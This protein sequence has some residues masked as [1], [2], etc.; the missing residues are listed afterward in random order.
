MTQSIKNTLIISTNELIV[1]RVSSCFQKN[2]FISV[3]TKNNAAEQIAIEAPSLIILDFSDWE[4]GFSIL[5]EILND[6]W[7]HHQS[8]IALCGT[9]EVSRS[10]DHNKSINLIATISRTK[11]ATELP[12]ILGMLR[13]N[14]LL[15][16]KRAHTQQKSSTIVG[17]TIVHNNLAEI[18]SIINLIC[19]Y[20]YNSN[21]I[22]INSRNS[23]FMGLTELFVN[24]FEHGN[25]G[26]SYTEKREWLENKAPIA[27]LFKK[28]MQDSAIAKRVIHLDYTIDSV[29]STFTITDEGEGFSWKKYIQSTID[30]ES[31]LGTNGRGIVMAQTS[32]DTLSYNAKGT[33]VTTSISHQAP[34]SNLIPI[35]LE[36][37]KPIT[38]AKGATLINAGDA[39]DTLYFICKGTFDI[40]LDRR[41]ISFLTPDD[42]FIGEISF[43][44]HIA[45]SATV[46]ANEESLVIP[47]TREQFTKMSHRFPYYSLF[48]ARLLAQRV[49]RQNNLA[50]EN[51]TFND[52]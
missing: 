45:R 3:F 33:A 21:R 48:I 30:Y 8:I 26:I 14:S 6:P 52:L 12:L 9:Y 41:K 39:S 32:F 4:Q 22:S 18:E 7:L 35:I 13:E 31:F 15:I 20:L 10:I 28:K 50:M 2:E 25:L 36:G 38:V 40:L 44:L 24:A 17:K 37:L 42:I 49:V 23:L 5:D 47:I 1:S 43:L 19:A 34:Q 46:T 51:S 11:I 16:F 29:G 27:L